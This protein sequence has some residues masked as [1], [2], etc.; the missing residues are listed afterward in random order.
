MNMDTLGSWFNNNQGIL[1]VILFV[2]APLSGFLMWLFKKFFLKKPKK[3]SPPKKSPPIKGI[4]N[5]GRDVNVGGDIIG[6][7]RNITH[8][9]YTTVTGHN[10]EQPIIEVKMNSF[11]SVQGRRVLSLSLR[12]IG[13]VP[14]IIYDLQLAEER[15][16]ITS[17][18]LP[19]H[20]NWVSQSF[21]ISNFK[22]LLEKNDYALLE[23]FYKNIYNELGKTTAKV[24]QQSRADNGYNIKSI[25]I[26]EYQTPDKVKSQAQEGR[27]ILLEP[28]TSDIWDKVF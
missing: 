9:A 25:N 28:L 16:E 1:A 13:Y 12:N 24:T 20:S 18:T 19:P 15:L 6:E 26:E 21:N 7:Q 3:R 22:I 2:V 4:V 10:K 14:G 27:M 5:A 23:V 11:S 8:N 17:I